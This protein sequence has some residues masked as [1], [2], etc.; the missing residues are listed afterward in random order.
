MEISWKCHLTF[1]NHST[2]SDW[3][4]KVLHGGGNAAVSGVRIGDDGIPWAMMLGATEGSGCKWLQPYNYSYLCM[5]V[6][7]S[8]YLSIYLI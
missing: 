7:L 3:I 5:Y 4:A 6:Y 1:S 8:I 2:D